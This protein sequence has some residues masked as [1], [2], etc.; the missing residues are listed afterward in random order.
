[1][2][3]QTTPKSPDSTLPQSR[4][5]LHCQKDEKNGMGGVVEGRRGGEGERGCVE[6]ERREET[7]S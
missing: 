5:A 2:R 3:I 4:T 6:G 7:V 1:M